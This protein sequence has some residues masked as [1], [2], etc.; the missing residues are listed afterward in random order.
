[1]RLTL[2]T[3]S[4]GSA[5]LLTVAAIGLQYALPGWA[6]AESFEVKGR[7]WG[8]G[9]G[10]SQ[11]GA[12]GYA[13]R[14][15]NYKQI[16]DHYYNGTKV[17][18]PGQADDVVRVLLMTGS[19]F[20]LSGASRADQIK[21]MP[22]RQ[23][24][25]SGGS[26]LTVRTFG[27]KKVGRSDAPLIVS[28][29]GPVKLYGTAINGIS[30]GR[31]RGEI[32]IRRRSGELLA[33][34][35]V[36]T[37]SYLKGVVP[38]EVPSEWPQAAVRAQAVAARS[39]ALATKKSGDIFDLYPDTRSQFY[40]GAD[41]EEKGS[42][43]AVQATSGEVVTYKGK[44]VATYYFSTSGGKTESIEYVWAGSDPVP[45]LVSVDDPYEQGAPYRRWGPIKYSR[46]SLTSK[47]GSYVK[48]SLK[49]VEVTQRGPGERAYKVKIVGSKGSSTIYGTTFQSLL[50]LRSSWF[51]L[52]KVY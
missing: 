5:F 47:L 26:K 3:V 22:G 14:G 33:I 9:I 18:R 44:V 25:V 17:V 2:H 43:E 16:L 24:T 28:G 49:D 45:Y 19:S 8:H 39:Y 7:G 13:K 23:Y 34:N 40:G 42:S 46:S 41:G 38:R 30:N 21:L 20:K 37:D 4:K 50:G 29:P 48:G 32:V 6:G 31:F 10:M 51:Y 11:W 12:H 52:H 1:M 15:L 36:A 35:R 27:G